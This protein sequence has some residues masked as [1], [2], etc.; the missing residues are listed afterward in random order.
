MGLF[1]NIKNLFRS[2]A[3][4]AADATENTAVNAKYD[5]QDAEKQLMEYRSSI[6]KALA[7][8]KSLERKRDAA[9]AEQSKFEK[10]ATLALEQGNE[11]DA[12][13]ALE[14]AEGHERVYD[15]FK[16]QITANNALITN[17]RKQ[18]DASEGKVATAKNDLQILTA[19]EESLQVRKAMSSAN[20]K[21]GNTGALGRIGS[22]R[23][24][25]QSQE[26]ELLAMEEISV[27]ATD[28]LEEKY[29]VSSSS[30]DDKLA[31]LKAKMK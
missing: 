21:F 3:D 26:D 12:R 6:T 25:V 4:A 5:I 27:D 17:M 30:V 15:D 19:R 10:L 14:A 20:K 23:E 7:S 31:K 24:K 28:S 9:K 1:N 13:T 29:S 18:L 8:N 16:R 2:A 22:Y 11:N